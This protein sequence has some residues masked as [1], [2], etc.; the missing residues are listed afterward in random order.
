[1][2][3]QGTKYHR[4]WATT[5]NSATDP[6]EGAYIR[7]GRKNEKWGKGGGKRKREER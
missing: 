2:Q 1:M 3:F 5:R 7:K 6:T 4:N